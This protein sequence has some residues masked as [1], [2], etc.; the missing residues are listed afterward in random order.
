MKRS[1][2]C[3]ILI[4]G[5]FSCENKS[6]VVPDGVVSDSLMTALIVDLAIVDASYSVSLTSPTFPRFRKEL[7]YEEVVKKH[8]TSREQFVKS[9]QFY[10]QNTKRLQLIYENALKE[11]SKRQAEAVR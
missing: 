10:A 4:F 5:L 2:V 1:I 6:H 3:L 9:L 7:F 11:L 8:G